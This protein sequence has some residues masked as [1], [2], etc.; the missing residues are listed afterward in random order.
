[1]LKNLKV[2]ALTFIILLFSAMVFVAK[3][4]EVVSLCNACS[5]SQ[6]EKIALKSQ[7]Y[8][9]R[10]HVVD[11]T[12]GQVKSF[13]VEHDFEPG[14]EFHYAIPVTTSNEA[15]T[16]ARAVNRLDAIAGI[17]GSLKNA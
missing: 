7:T 10:V 16:A 9:G 1:M 6:I 11:F 4:G 12:T 14:F 15:F 5:P 17:L 3:A 2:S 13:D 8:G